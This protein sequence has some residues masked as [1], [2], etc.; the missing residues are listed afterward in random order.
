M[1]ANGQLGP[2]LDTN[3]FLTPMCQGFVTKCVKVAALLVPCAE[4]VSSYRVFVSMRS[5]WPFDLVLEGCAPR[6][7][8]VQEQ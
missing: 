1:F 6:G 4:F 5:F 8:V 3:T 2:A 7:M